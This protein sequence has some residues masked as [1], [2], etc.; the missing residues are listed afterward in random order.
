MNDQTTEMNT[1]SAALTQHIARRD[2]VVHQG[3]SP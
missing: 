1:P 2:V 3:D